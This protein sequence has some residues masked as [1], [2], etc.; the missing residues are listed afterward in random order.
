MFQS[1]MRS[2]PLLRHTRSHCPAKHFQGWQARAELTQQAGNTRDDSALTQYRRHDCDT[3]ICC[4]SIRVLDAKHLHRRQAHRFGRHGGGGWRC[5]FR[6][7]PARA[8]IEFDDASRIEQIVAWANRGL[9]C[10]E[11]AQV[12]MWRK[13]VRQVGCWLCRHPRLEFES[14]ENKMIAGR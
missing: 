9:L 7:R 10:V 14:P 11:K 1:P 5:R 6:R 12:G 3:R 13:Y 4:C 2:V 8:S